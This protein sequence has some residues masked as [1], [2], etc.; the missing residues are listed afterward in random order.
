MKSD[1]D[2]LVIGAGPTGS[3]LALDLARRRLRVRIVERN[4][5]GFPGSR[6]KGVQPRSLEVLE[7]L[8]VLPDVLAAGST[9]PP[10]GIHLG[11]FTVPKRMFKPAR[12]TDAIP[13]PNTWLIPQFSTDA[14]ILAWGKKICLGT[15]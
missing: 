13:Y 12:P 11:W 8:G 9:Y 4:A 5:H 14:L 3:T 10:L 7:D 15:G 6:A 1:I 2:V